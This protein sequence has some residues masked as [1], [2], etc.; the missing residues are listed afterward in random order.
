MGWFNHQLDMHLQP[1]PPK[2]CV[3][4]AATPQRTVRPFVF[5]FVTPSSWYEATAQPL[6]AGLG[7][8]QD[9]ARGLMF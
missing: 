1:C 2:K 8:L 7:A 5:F 3:F 9:A 6:E 4:F